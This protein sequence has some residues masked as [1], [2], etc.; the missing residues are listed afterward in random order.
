MERVEQEAKQREKEIREKEARE[1]EAREAAKLHP[2]S[3]GKENVANDGYTHQRGADRGNARDQDGSL[4]VIRLVVFLS[5][6]CYAVITFFSPTSQARTRH[7][8]QIP[9]L[10]SWFACQSAQSPS[11]F[12]WFSYQRISKCGLE[13]E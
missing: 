12:R 4:D 9:A 7:S 13:T 2:Q 3:A 11:R 5:M 1:K 8:R 6:L 10:R